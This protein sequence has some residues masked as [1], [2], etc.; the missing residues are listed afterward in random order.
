MEAAQQGISA[1]ESIKASGPL[2]VVLAAGLI[3]L[4]FAW[5]SERKGRETERNEFVAFLKEL[6]KN[7]RS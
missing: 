3:A 6:L 5:A 4:W 7:D 1:W 2:A